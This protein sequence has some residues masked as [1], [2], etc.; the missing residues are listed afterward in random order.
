MRGQGDD[1]PA[2]HRGGDLA[3]GQLPR[4]VPPEPAQPAVAAA[5]HDAPACAAGSV[6]PA[7]FPSPGGEAAV[8]N[9]EYRTG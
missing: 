5:H 1:G 3:S 9:C 6:N 4:P 7:G 8:P 2:C